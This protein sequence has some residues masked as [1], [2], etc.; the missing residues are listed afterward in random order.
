MPA[1][2]RVSADDQL[3]PFVSAVPGAAWPALPGARGMATATLLYQME[4]T[5]WWSPERLRAAQAGQLRELVAHARA[6]VP[7]YRDRL[8]G[9]PDSGDADAFYDAWRRLPVLRRDE[10]HAAGEAL[11][12]TAVPEAHGGWDEIATSGSTGTPVRVRRTQLFGLVW[13]AVTYRDHL[14]HR[15]DLTGTLAVLRE[16]GKGKAA[17]PDGDRWEHWGGGP[18]LFQSGPCVGLNVMTPVADQLEWLVRMDPDYLLSFPTLLAELAALSRRTGKRP[19]KLRQ[20]ETISE[21]L[22]P[23]QR[24]TIEDAWGAPVV[25]LYSAREAGYLGLQCPES[26]AL[27][28]PAEAVLLEVLDEDGG[29]CAP[30][31]T[32]RVVVTPLH[33][34]ATPLIRYDIG[35]FAA[36]GQPC[37]C[38]RGLPVI[39][40]VF[41]RR[42]NMLV[43]PDGTSKVTLLSSSDLQDIAACAPVRRYQFVQ[44]TTDLL[45]LRVV[46]E[47]GL[48]DDQASALQRWAAAKF[49]FPG[50]VMVIGVPDLPRSP[51]G[52]FEDFIS[53]VEAS[54]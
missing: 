33:N 20:V 1:G 2:G 23:A 51:S 47:D 54:T 24:A 6:T 13:S 21:I 22:S 15:R 44:R 4:Q 45:E 49:Q 39:S 52:K 3:P 38:G 37:A 50:T 17:Y 48:S 41:G 29:W 11:H 46:A 42:Q 10:V 28:V 25:N 9:L 16:S 7:F 30:G 36:V 35:D 19:A 26:H 43:M 32:G 53:L 5:Q 8:G 27:H 31:E 14:W 34:F 18:T 12:S 40:Q